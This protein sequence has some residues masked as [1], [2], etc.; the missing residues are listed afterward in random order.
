MTTLFRA[1]YE[2][3][4]STLRPLEEVDLPEGELLVVARPLQGNGQLDGEGIPVQN[5]LADILGFDPDD[6]EQSRR[7]AESQ[8]QALQL[9]LSRLAALGIDEALHNLPPSDSDLDSILYDEQ[10][11]QEI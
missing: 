1:V 5:S 8:Y 10:G 11:R 3:Q 6:E 4:S 9:S 7:L 2:R